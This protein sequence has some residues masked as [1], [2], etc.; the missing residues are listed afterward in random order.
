MPGRVSL[1][2][3]DFRSDTVTQPTD[4]MRHAMA[5]AEVGDDVYGEDPTVIRLEREAARILGMEAAILMPTGTMANQAAVWV[6]TGRGGAVVCEEHCHLSL[7]EG[8]ASAL[9]SNATLKTVAGRNGVF[10]PE[11]MA[12]HFLPRD[13][14]FSEVRLVATENTHNY[15]GG[16]TWSV[17]QTRAVVEAAHARGVPVHVDGARIFN[18]AVAQGVAADRL[19]A[20]ADSVMVSL[21][22]GLSAPL[23]SVL[24]GTREFVA[25]ARFARKVLG[26]GMRQAGHI[27][28]A[29]LVALRDG[30]PRLGEDHRNALRLAQGLAGLPGIRVDLASVETNMVM[31]DIAGTGA[32]SAQ[33]LERMKQ[34]GVLGN[35]RDAGPTIRFVTHR[36]VSAADCDEAVARLAAM[37]R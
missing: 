33:F 26:G 35:V 32:S 19:V 7:Y 10:A 23:G 16:R 24:C 1:R 25:E 15:S 3:L 5:T 29:G 22:K 2:P 13:P 20:G 30:I 31:A 21:S 14:H 8:G 36:N 34:V 37:L 11:D 6:H 12:R 4:A 17:A 27:A 9:L 28:A 18:A